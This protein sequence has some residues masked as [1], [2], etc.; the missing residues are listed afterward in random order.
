MDVKKKK[1]ILLWIGVV[2][3]LIVALLFSVPFLKNK[4]NNADFAGDNGNETSRDG[5]EVPIDDIRNDIEGEVKQAIFTISY[6]SQD[7]SSPYLYVYN[8]NTYEFYDSIS[9]EK[10]PV[11]RAGKF[12]YDI[13][14]IVENIM[15]SGVNEERLYNVRYKEKEY[16]VSASNK[17]LS[18]FLQLIDVNMETCIKE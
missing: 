5:A 18:E 10:P 11:P 3:V 14:K 17:E 9:K 8:D 1:W 12:D 15:D 7:C 16:I 13:I 2:I 6:I 4:E